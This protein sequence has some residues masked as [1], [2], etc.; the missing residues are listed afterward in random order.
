MTCRKCFNC[1]L[2]L[3]VVSATSMLYTCAG[4]SGAART[5]AKSEILNVLSELTLRQR[6]GQRFIGWVPREGFAGDVK[7]LTEAGEIGGFIVYKWNFETIEDIRKLSTDMQRAAI[8]GSAGLP[9]FL[10]ADQE[11]GRVAAFRFTEFVRLP[12]AFH[13]AGILPPEAI[14]D[15]AYFNALQLRHVGINMNLAPVLD[16]YPFPD[17]TIIGDRSFG[18]DE[19]SV[20]EAGVSF[21][22]GSLRGGVLPVIKHFPG[23]GLSV[24]D[25]HG[26]LPVI[27]SLEDEELER[28]LLPFRTAIEAQ[29]P[30]VMPAH[31]LFPALDAVYPVTLSTVFIQNLL[32]EELGFSGLIVSDGLS[33]GA[34]S[35]HYSLEDTLVRCFQVGIDVLLVHTEYSI[36]E[37]IDSVVRLVDEG[38]ITESQINEGTLR[39]LTVKRETGILNAA[40]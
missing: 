36:R 35:K 9:L 13:L 23:H 37:L 38:K 11:G 27:E 32:R 2:I 28:H 34:L 15:A 33:M 21:I 31:M 6:I 14:E 5:S 7:E 10:A 39:V 19:E 17:N 8:G 12:P 4:I 22:R 40:I 24:V 1:I 18:P 16:L 20:A 29:A 3:I 30:A 25:S 26:E